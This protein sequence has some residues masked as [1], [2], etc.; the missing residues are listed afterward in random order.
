MR[1]AYAL[2]NAHDFR[3]CAFRNARGTAEHFRETFHDDGQLDMARLARLYVEELPADTPIRVDHVPAMAAADANDG[4]GAT[5]RL[6]A[7]GYLKGL[8]ER[9]KEP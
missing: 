9:V 8:L 1:R 6:F 5:G 4:Y 7:I 2:G 3:G